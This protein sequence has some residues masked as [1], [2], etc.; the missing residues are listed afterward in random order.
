MKK[1]RFCY[2]SLFALAAGMFSACSSDETMSDV[3]GPDGAT[4]Y[5]KVSISFTGT[6]R[7]G[8]RSFGAS[9]TFEDGTPDESTIN[10]LLFIF[11]DEDGRAVGH[12]KLTKTTTPAIPEPTH[13]ANTN[14]QD[15]Y[16]IE[17]PVNLAPGSKTPTHI[18][19][20]ANPITEGD[21]YVNLSNVYELKRSDYKSTNGFTMNNS[22]YYDKQNRVIATKIP[23]DGIKM[24]GAATPATLAATDIYIERIA[25]KVSVTAP[26]NLTVAPYEINNNT[27][28][29]FIPEYWSVTAT[30]KETKLV[31]DLPATL[32]A[33][34]DKVTPW[35]NDTYRTFWAHSVSYMPTF[36]DK[37]FPLTG[38][39]VNATT[40]LNYLSYNDII[41]KKPTAVGTSAWGGAQYFLETTGRSE[42]L[43]YTSI[44]GNLAL[45]NAIIIGHYEVYS[46]KGMQNKIDKFNT[47]NGFYRYASELF[48]K[49]DIMGAMLS[50]HATYLRTAEN[51][52]L[53]DAQINSLFAITPVKKF[54]RNNIETDAAKHYVAPQAT[55]ESLIENLEYFNGT[56][57]VK[58]DADNLAEFN[59]FIVKQ[60]NCA[61]S[62][63]QGGKAFFTVLVEHRG[64]DNNTVIEGTYG[65]VR[66]HTYKINVTKIAGLASGIN[67]LTDPLLP[68]ADEVARFKVDAHLNVLAWH[69]VTQSVEL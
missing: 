26:D 62:Y 49:D 54:Y 33:N 37:G 15:K 48:T 35:I 10:T 55:G 3:V 25:T 32:S 23:A 17:V 47:A 46:D 5:A 30:E 1:N 67:S 2:L 27:Y 42:R 57:W 34:N 50:N 9:D 16:T 11:Y 13:T 7:F 12:T 24:E 68:L 22:V 40:K 58:V 4:A 51:T 14:V 21:Q 53:T 69:V 39:D 6:D 65:L 8:A 66:N 28:L 19:C 31:K 29:K 45:P 20:F 44:N 64:K 56:N 52:P 43:S 61:I 63:A 38:W 18:M 41:A 60:T 36:S 59:K